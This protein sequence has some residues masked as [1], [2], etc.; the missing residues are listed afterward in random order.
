MTSSPTPALCEERS[1]GRSLPPNVIQET[2]LALKNGATLLASLVGTLGVAVAVRI[3]MPRYLGP[4][5]FGRLHFAEEFAAASLF[6]TT[7]GIE[8]YIKREVATRPALASEFFGGLVQVR[9]LASIVVALGMAGILSLMGKPF[10]DWGLVYLFG[11]G[12]VAF[13]LNLSLA[14]FLQAVGR[15]RE[16]AITNVA[17]KFL[18]GLGIVVGIALTGSLLVVPVTFLLT[19]VL[20]VPALYWA[21]RRHLDLKLRPAI[22]P[23]VAVLGFSLPFYLNQI[24]HELYAR[25]GVTT[26]SS[27]ASDVE[28]GWFGAA[29][30]VKTLVLLAVPILN[31]VL[32]PMSSRLVRE[33][34]TVLN[35]VMQSAV[36]ITLVVT[37]PLSLVLVL[38]ADVV[39]QTLFS[40][41]F[42]PAARSLRALAA[43]IPLSAFCVI[44]AMHILQLGRIWTITVISIAGLA[45]AAVLNPLLV[46][47][48][49][50]HLG[51]GGGGL[52]AGVAAMSTEAIVALS[53][54]AA[55][56]SAAGMRRLG[57]V[58]ARLV[59]VTG[60]V[61]L[62]HMAAAPAGLAG[63][64][65]DAT[66]W[67]ALG[68]AAGV[69][70]ARE[71]ATRLRRLKRELRRGRDAN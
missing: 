41:E 59:L 23:M 32:L 67:L 6:L 68:T 65:L 50:A 55:L 61:S 62:A 42:A 64:F 52:G 70:P 31:A 27:F 26:L 45:V 66:L 8:T 44:A 11:L 57:T 21:C 48:G 22:G 16:L 51:A 1:G 5:A 3:W 53:M 71:L 39:V 35:D 37:T 58:I 15:V 9:L 47:I 13:I 34:V 46:R 56:G 33:S 36:R 18:W 28:V 19:E 54:L 60:A 7:L 2:K 30:H 14:A 29:N 4:D 43:M 69:I 25:L 63:V 10:G 49:V 38:N 20:K 24:S 17:S 40:H 12:Q